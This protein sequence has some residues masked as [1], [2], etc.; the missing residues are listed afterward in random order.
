MPDCRIA[1]PTP[2]FINTIYYKI[3]LSSRGHIGCS[4]AFSGITKSSGSHQVLQGLTRPYWVLIG[5]IRH[6]MV[7]YFLLCTP[8]GQK[9]CVNLAK[10]Y[11][12]KMTYLITIH[13]NSTVSDIRL[14][15]KLHNKV[16]FKKC[17]HI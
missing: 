7:S 3:S 16:I 8:P 9:K 12:D 4:R 10:F 5:L 15:R 14:S 13:F 1:Q 11:S 2:S 6:H 17:T